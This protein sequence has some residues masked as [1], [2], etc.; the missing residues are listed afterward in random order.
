MTVLTVPPDSHVGQAGLD[1]SMSFG[2][3]NSSAALGMSLASSAGFS[4][5]N[6]PR[7]PPETPGGAAAGGQFAASSSQA[8]APVQSSNDA[9]FEALQRELSKLAEHNKALEA[10][11]A[12]TAV[13]SMPATP[14]MP[15]MQ[16]PVA[17]I[18][19]LFGGSMTL[20]ESGRSQAA[21][22]ACQAAP[23]MAVAW[24]SSKPPDVLRL[25]FLRHDS[26]CRGRLGVPELEACA[27]ELFGQAVSPAVLEVARSFRDGVDRAG[28]YRWFDKV[29]RVVLATLSD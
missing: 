3:G 24:R 28:F 16:A 11:L 19:P 17:P 13:P 18:Q 2:L 1:T 10:K 26:S 23:S 29:E 9:A 15:S 6:G 27:N 12:R 20:A 21:P 14:S 25:L 4:S 5:S 7:A 22:L 8:L